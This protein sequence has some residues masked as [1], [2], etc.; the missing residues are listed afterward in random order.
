MLLPCQNWS[1][2]GKLCKW[3][4]T[5][6]AQPLAWYKYVLAPSVS[7][8]HQ[9]TEITNSLKFSQ[10]KKKYTWKKSWD[11]GHSWFICALIPRFLTFRSPFSQ[12]KKKR[13][14]K[15]TVSSETTTERRYRHPSKI[16]AVKGQDDVGNIELLIYESSWKRPL[17]K[18]KQENQG[19]SSQSNG[20]AA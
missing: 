18:Q 13:G 3:A 6:P 4:L 15:K 9:G 16:M 2:L 14:K 17:S 5:A 11:A 1:E 7:L 20:E 19:P 10:R 8:L 12:E